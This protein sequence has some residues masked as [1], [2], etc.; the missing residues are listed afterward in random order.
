MKD[1]TGILSDHLEYAV[2]KPL[3]KN[4]DRSSI[5]NY[6]PISLL[7]V[8]SKIIEKT[9]HSRLNQHLNTNNILAT[10]QYGFRKNQS[11]DHAAYTLVNG[12]LQAWNSKLQVAGIFCDLAKA[13]DCVN[14]DILKKS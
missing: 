2:V 12:I 7:P 10:E 3:F 13:F 14:H 4:G 9:I 1:K 5:L 6:R 8:F 11:T